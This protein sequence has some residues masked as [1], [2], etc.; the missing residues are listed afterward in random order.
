MVEKKNDCLKPEGG[1]LYVIERLTAEDSMERRDRTA[2]YNNA[3]YLATKKDDDY[4]MVGK[5]KVRE[6]F[7]GE[8]TLTELLTEYIERKV[9]LKY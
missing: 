2:T 1:E 6:T 3:I 7:A 9:T 5:Y 8:A 4:V